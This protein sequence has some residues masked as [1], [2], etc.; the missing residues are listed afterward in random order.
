MLNLINAILIWHDMFRKD[1]RGYAALLLALSSVSCSSFTSSFNMPVRASEFHQSKVIGCSLEYEKRDIDPTRRSVKERKDYALEEIVFKSSSDSYKNDSVE[2]KLY[3]QKIGDKPVILFF[4][5]LW[6]EDFTEEICEDLARGGYNVAQI[7]PKH[8]FL[9]HENDIG[10]SVS[11]MRESIEDARNLIDYL[12]KEEGFEHFLVSGVSLGGI[13]AS[14]LSGIDRRIEGGA[15]IN[16]G[17]NLAELIS[18]SGY[19]YVERFREYRKEQEK[20]SDEELDRMIKDATY[21]IDPITY[22]HRINPRN[23]IFIRSKD[24]DIFIKESS[25]GLYNAMGCPETVILPGGHFA[26]GYRNLIIRE[27]MKK[28]DKMYA[29]DSACINEDHYD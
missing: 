25:I 12:K 9:W 20:I 2:V 4:P 16:T 27:V 7:K 19:H 14:L 1:V 17:G 6:M 22:A 3:N 15:L 11:L 21:C 26:L 23:F 13:Q 24:D 8:G 10:F 18:K 28:F 5:G 29:S